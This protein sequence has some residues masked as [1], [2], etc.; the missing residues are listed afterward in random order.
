MKNIVEYLSLFCFDCYRLVI[1]P[2]RMKLFSHHKKVGEARYKALLKDRET[3]VNT[4]PHC[5]NNL[6]DF[7]FDEDYKFYRKYKNRTFPVQI[8]EI[9]QIFDNIPECDIEELGLDS[10]V[11]HP[12]HLLLGAL[13]VI[14]PCARSYVKNASGINHDDLTFKYQEIIKAVQ[15]YYEQ[16]DN[17]KQ[18]QD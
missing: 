7:T 10:K 6:P 15:K 4:C 17:S 3:S 1:S 14:P 11:V 5:N 16:G 9:E 2:D 8:R 18:R 12:S 13:L